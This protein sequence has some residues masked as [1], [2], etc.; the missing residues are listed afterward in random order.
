MGGGEEPRGRLRPPP[1]SLLRVE[2]EASIP[3]VKRR[4]NERIKSESYVRQ[5]LVTQTARLRAARLEMS[6]KKVVVQG[7]ARSC[8]GS[9]LG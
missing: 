7:P 5:M 9:A 1:E 4:V 6:M 8:H 2:K 3:V